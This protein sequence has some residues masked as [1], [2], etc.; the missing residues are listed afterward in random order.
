MIK[1]SF[2]APRSAFVANLGYVCSTLRLR[3]AECKQ[4]LGV[5]F[6]EYQNVYQ[7][8]DSG[9]GV[10]PPVMQ[11]HAYENQQ[12]CP[13]LLT[14]EQDQSVL[15]PNRRWFLLLVSGLPVLQ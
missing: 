2:C 15:Y 3:Y 6:F 1:L 11:P 14:S 7:H 12:P 9:Y 8:T 4:D 5:R 13:K 10:Q